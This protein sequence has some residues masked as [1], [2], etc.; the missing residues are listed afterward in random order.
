MSKNPKAI[1]HAALSLAGGAFNAALLVAFAYAAFRLWGMSQGFVVAGG[2]LPSPTLE[3][4]RAAASM[5]GVESRVFYLALAWCCLVAACGSAW[6]ALL[7][8]RW[9]FHAVRRHLAA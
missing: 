6:M 8:A 9:A 3:W 4:V 1:G 2:G 5:P 7:G